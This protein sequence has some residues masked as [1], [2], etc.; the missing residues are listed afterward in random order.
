MSE[1][2]DIARRKI[3]AEELLEAIGEI[4]DE[5]IKAAEDAA[6]LR[7]KRIYMIRRWSVLAAS[8]CIVLVVG[9]SAWRLGEGSLKKDG[10]QSQSAIVDTSEDNTYDMAIEE[11][12]LWFTAGAVK[13]EVLK[14]YK[15]ANEQET[16]GRTEAAQDMQQDMEQ[17]S[18][19]EESPVEKLAGVDEPLFVGYEGDLYVAT[20]DFAVEDDVRIARSGQLSLAQE[21][22]FD[23]YVVEGRPELVTIFING[24]FAVYQRIYDFE[25]EIEGL[26][27]GLQHIAALPQP[28]EIIRDGVDF[29]IYENAGE[30]GEGSYLI[31]LSAY[32]CRAY[33]ELFTS[34]ENWAE[35]WWSVGPID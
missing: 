33:P 35:F 5:K 29:T 30:E 10:T 1:K 26:T 21:Y 12:V 6:L 31:N 7:S 22:S 4:G 3:S 13:E 32:L 27:Y 11:D 24:G 28:G 2:Q 8:A 15:P 25:L 17:N 34:E 23:A 19:K 18:V 20:D 9:Y 14:E 16:V